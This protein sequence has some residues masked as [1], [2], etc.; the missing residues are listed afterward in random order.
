M[1]PSNR[2]RALCALDDFSH[3]RVLGTGVDQDPYSSTFAQFVLPE[4]DT[5]CSHCNARLHKNEPKGMCCNRGKVDLPLLPD[6][7]PP[8][9]SLLVGD[10]DHF[11]RNIRKYNR[12]SRQSSSTL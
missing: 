4:M 6:L 7:P 8:L 1:A 10:D 3:E 5:Q 11:R 12:T 9:H 2:G